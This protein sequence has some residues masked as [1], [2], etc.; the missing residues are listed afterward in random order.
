M[1]GFQ[2]VNDTSANEFDLSWQDAH[3]GSS[4][5]QF[6][7]RLQQALFQ[8]PKLDRIAGAGN[9]QRIAQSRLLSKPSDGN[10]ASAEPAPKFFCCRSPRK[11]KI[12]F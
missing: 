2:F 11:H 9:P 5:S 4:G 8:E 1:A 3:R 6:S 7:Q 10:A 12:T